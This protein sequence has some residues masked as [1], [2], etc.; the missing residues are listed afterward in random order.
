[1]LS[2]GCNSTRH[3]FF[4]VHINQTETG[5]LRKLSR[6]WA[7]WDRRGVQDGTAGQR[8][9]M[10]LISDKDLISCSRSYCRRFLVIDG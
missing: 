6:L 5:L 7:L 1:M 10:P 8:V 3:N 2:L 4:A 9:D